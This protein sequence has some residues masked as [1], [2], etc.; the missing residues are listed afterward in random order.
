M[1][2]LLFFFSCDVQNKLEELAHARGVASE[3]KEENKR[4]VSTM[5]VGGMVAVGQSA[6]LVVVLD[7]S[8]DGNQSRAT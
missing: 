6:A 3:L 1:G 4:L 2:T 5:I 8:H 7:G